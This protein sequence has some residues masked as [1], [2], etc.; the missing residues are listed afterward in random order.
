MG[1]ITGPDTNKRFTKMLEIVNSLISSGVM[2][3]DKSEAY[4]RGYFDSE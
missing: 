2:Q 4:S 1:N 3:R